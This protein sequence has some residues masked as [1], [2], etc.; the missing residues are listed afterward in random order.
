MSRLSLT[1][2]ASILRMWK[3]ST[4]IS[5]PRIRLLLPLVRKGFVDQHDGDVIFDLVDQ[6]AR[7]TDK[8][9]P[10]PIQDNITLALGARQNI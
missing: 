8:P 3:Q 9:V 4:L 1:A 6:A 5:K 7:L 10:G 2:S